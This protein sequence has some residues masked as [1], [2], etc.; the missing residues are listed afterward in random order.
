[1]PGSKAANALMLWFLPPALREADP[2]ILRRAKLCVAYNLTVPLWGPAFAVL[3]WALGQPVIAAI[4]AATTFAT[5]IPLLTLRKTGS[6]TLAGNLM[7]AIMFVGI[8]ACTWLEGGLGAPGVLWFPLV[9][10]LSMLIAGRRAG[11]AWSAAFVA[12]LVGY[13]VLEGLDLRPAFSLDA[14]TLSLLHLSLAASAIIVGLVFAVLFESLKVDALRS[15]ETANNSL[16]HA[17]DE[18]E[19]ATNA[20]SDFLAIM[21]HEIRTPIHG[22]FGMTELALDTTDDGKRRDFLARVRGCAETLLTIINDIL[23]FSRIEAR[24]L[25][26]EDAEFDP[27]T[28]LDGVLDTLATQAIEKRLELVGS[29]DDR[30]PARLR[31]DAGRLRQILVNLVDN[32]VKFTDRGEVVVRLEPGASDSDDPASFVLCGTV[33]DT[34]IGIPRD[35][36][37]AIFE[38]FTQVE[39]WTTTRYAGTGLG[40]AI[41]RRLVTLMGGEVSV[42]SEPGLGSTFRFS[43]HLEAVAPPPEARRLEPPGLRVLV[44]DA[45]AAARANVLDTVRALD[46]E[47]EGA[48]DGGA[49]LALLGRAREIA[50]DAVVAGLPADE[51]GRERLIEQLRAAGTAVP[52]VALVAPTRTSASSRTPA[53]AAVVSKPIKT[54]ALYAA[55]DVALRCVRAGKRAGAGRS[56]VSGPGEFG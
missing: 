15:L 19:A 44:V 29:A 49:M 46:V 26:L 23:D 43:A 10:M 25:V 39:S 47:A 22:I 48:T 9:P 30:L 50:F 24:K 34:G 12:A 4:I 17:R 37:S 53:F 2:D 14:H 3:L 5:A 31:G 42:D 8:V 21:S 11:I 36:L 13:Y 55:L 33:R 45:N 52:V 35:K 32:A 1:M 6:L 40:L 18:A 7:S 54:G 41:T 28:V 27:R 20:K 16:A 51:T 38:A 56:A